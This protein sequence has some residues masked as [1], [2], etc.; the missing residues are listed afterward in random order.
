MPN[1]QYTCPWCFCL[2]NAARIGFPLMSKT[3]KSVAEASLVSVYPIFCVF[4]IRRTA[5]TGN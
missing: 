4:A 1:R 5:L 2:L 3:N